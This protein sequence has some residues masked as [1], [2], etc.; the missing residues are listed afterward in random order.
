MGKRDTKK[1]GLR[2]V[3]AGLLDLLYPPRCVF[4]QRLLKDGEEHLCTA[5]QRSLPWT[6]P[7]DGPKRCEGLSQC[8]S[9]L[10][11]Q[12]AVRR[13]FHRYKFAGRSVYA[14]VYGLLMAQCVRDRLEGEWDLVTWAPLSARRRRRRGYDQAELLARAMGRL[15]GMEPAAL[16]R[17]LRDTPAQSSLD[18]EAARRA[19]AEGA[20]AVTDPAAVS[21][22]RV[23]LV[24][25]VVTTG[26]TLAQC[27]RVL[28]QAGAAEVA[29]VTLA[30]ARR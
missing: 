20:Y 14:Q 16:L 4:C 7:E 12:A 8:V 24:D 21:G 9:P 17:K 13:S 25:D 11:Y 19:N 23:L 2:A 29:G 26:S 30:R 6:A 28:R 18:G 5:C 10:W 27:A 15:L 3:L 22:R 1:G